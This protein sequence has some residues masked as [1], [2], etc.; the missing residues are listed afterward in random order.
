MLKKIISL[1]ADGFRS[2]KTGKKLWAIIF[3]KIFIMFAVLKVFFFPDYLKTNFKNDEER[4]AYVLD[5]ITR[6]PRPNK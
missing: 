6:L 1:Y 5:N 4:A 2:M 3:I